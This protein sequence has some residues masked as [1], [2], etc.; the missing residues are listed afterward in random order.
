MNHLLPF[1]LCLAGFAALALAMDRQQHDLFGRRLPTRSSAGLRLV[2]TAALL[3]ALAALVGWQG[4]GLGLVMVSGHT[5]LAAGIVHAA[6]IAYVRWSAHAGG[7]V[8][9][10][11][12]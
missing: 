4:W 3:A 8:R 11:K 1:V 6:L 2:G 12:R 7:G 10:M 9:A 5:S